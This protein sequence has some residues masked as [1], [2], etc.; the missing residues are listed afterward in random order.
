MVEITLWQGIK[1]ALETIS[2]GGT[3]KCVVWQRLEFIKYTYRITKMF[4]NKTIKGKRRVQEGEK[5]VWE[6]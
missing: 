1:S 3:V 4:K 5:G 6:L 2:M